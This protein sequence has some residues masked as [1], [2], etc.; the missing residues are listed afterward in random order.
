[1]IKGM[2]LSCQ[3]NNHII[4]SSCIMNRK[5]TTYFINH[6]SVTLSHKADKYLNGT[7]E[8]NFQLVPEVIQ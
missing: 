7:F 1:M 8:I 5:E 6:P 3:F 4:I 2:R